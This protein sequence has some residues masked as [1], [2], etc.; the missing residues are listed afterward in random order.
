MARTRRGIP[1]DSAN[2]GELTSLGARD[3]TQLGSES[4]QEGLAQIV[5]QLGG[6]L[7]RAPTPGQEFA[8]GDQDDGGVIG[9]D[10]RS[11]EAQLRPGGIG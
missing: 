5:H 9:G 3:G 2:V 1:I 10:G 8:E 7:L 4:G 11:T 6:Q